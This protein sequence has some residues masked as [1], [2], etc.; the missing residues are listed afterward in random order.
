[1]KNDGGTKIHCPFCKDFRV[2]ERID[3]S[4]FDQFNSYLGNFSDKQREAHWKYSDLSYF[5]RGRECKICQRKFITVEIHEAALKE[6]ADLRDKL[7]SI[8]NEAKEFDESASAGAHLSNLSDF[9]E[10]MQVLS[11]ED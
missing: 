6:L 7:V 9:L 4:N 2:C 11:Y 10:K 3:L 5:M 1:M 8:S